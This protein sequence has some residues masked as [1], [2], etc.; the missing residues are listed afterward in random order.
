[1]T[2]PTNA[3]RRLDD[4][5]K[6][7]V[8]GVPL[9]EAR[10]AGGAAYDGKRIVYAGGVKA[11]GVASEV[12]AFAPGDGAWTPAGRLPTAREHLAVTTDGA[13]KTFVLGGRVGGL[14]KN[15]G[16]RRRHREHRRRAHDRRAADGARWCRGVL[17][18]GVGR[19]PGRRRVTRRHEPAGR[20]H[21]PRRDPRASCRISAWRVTA[22]VPAV[23][24]GAAYVVLGGRQPGLFA[25]DVTEKI[26]LP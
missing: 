6:A 10:A 2:V 13:G 15:L 16:H 20:V 24:D 17:V 12:F 3:V 26:T 1:M 19:V 4:G 14:D 22:S 7:W 9:P 18:A 11:D 25:S 5:A 21:R 23:I 8:D